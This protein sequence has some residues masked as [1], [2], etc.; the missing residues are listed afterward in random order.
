MTEAD[1]VYRCAVPYRNS[2]FYRSA[3]SVNLDFSYQATSTQAARCPAGTYGE[4]NYAAASASSYISYP[5]AE[6]KAILA[7]QALAQ[8][9][10]NCTPYINRI[11]H[12]T[13]NATRQYPPGDSQLRD[14]RWHGTL[15]AGPVVFLGVYTVPVV[16]TFRIGLRIIFY[17]S[18]NL[19]DDVGW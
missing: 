14:C 17:L 9:T 3:A 8:A 7:A 5:D 6:A 13:F 2:N 1:L 12:R 15:A 4:G 10:L 11:A 16:G 18:V 19:N